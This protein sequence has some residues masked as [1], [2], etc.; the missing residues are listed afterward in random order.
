MEDYALFARML[1]GGARAVNVA[2]PLVY[3]RVGAEAFK[4][5]GGTGLLRSELRLQRE[6][7]REGFTSTA[8]Y[9]RNVAVRGGYRLIPWWCRR[10]VY[11]PMVAHYT[12][13]LDE[14]PRPRPRRR[15]RRRPEP[16]RGRS[17][18]RATACRSGTTGR[19]QPPA[20]GLTSRG[21]CAREHRPRGRRVRLL[22][23]DRRRAVRPRPGPA[24][25]RRRA[26]P[27]HRRERLQRARAADRDRDPPLR[28]APVPHLERPRLGVRQPVHGLHRLPAPGVLD[29]QG[30][31][32]PDADQPRH[33]LRVLRHARCPRT[34]RGRWSPSSR[35][36]CRPARPPTSSRRPCR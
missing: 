20:S 15:T 17:P 31:G 33:H 24:R 8:E 18:R 23:A 1:A 3:Y 9:V 34:R 6:F 30:P 16:G 19:R 10:A 27:P 2:E 36:R 14:P 35:P 7:R 5:R 12:E 4:R 11:R 21:R 25:A 13:R 26:P 29:L 22:R 32:V 28:R